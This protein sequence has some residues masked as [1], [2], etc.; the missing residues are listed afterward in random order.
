MNIKKYFEEYKWVFA[1]ALA[2]AFVAGVF[3]WQGDKY[4]AS[5][6]LTVSRVGTQSALDY[7]YDNY[8]A[9]KAADE[10]GSV[11]AGWFK[12]PEMAQV[13]YKKANLN[14]GSPS[15]AGLS[16]RFQAAK[17]SPSTV[18]VRF[19]AGS[20]SEAKILGQAIVSAAAEKANLLSY[21]SG[22]GVSF[23]V[24]GNEPVIINNSANVWQNVLVG[25]IMGLIFGVFVKVGK[26]YFKE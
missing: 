25:L 19:G 6:A 12:T 5:L 2:V 10:F 26:E 8:Y 18:E 21:F 16:R 17:I 9:L 22:Q 23:S 11:V 13:V 4:S 1:F 3:A 20:E 15:L 14:F 24:T 7:K